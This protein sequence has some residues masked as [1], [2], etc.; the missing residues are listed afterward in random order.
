MAAGAACSSALPALHP[1][2]GC[3]EL[4]ALSAHASA[5]WEERHQGD[6][7]YSLAM[8]SLRRGARIPVFASMPSKLDARQRASQSFILKRLSDFGLEART[9]GYTD[10]GMFNPLHEVRTLARH[11][12]GGIILG[13][14]QVGASRAKTKGYSIP[15]DPRSEVTDV[16]LP[17]P[18]FA[19]T[20]WNQLETGILFGLSLPLFVLREQGIAGGI[21]DEGAS[22][23]LIHSMP[24]PREDWTGGSG[25][26]PSID[27]TEAE[28]SFD[29]ALMRW[30]SIVWANYYRA[31]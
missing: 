19:P 3:T 21:F 30:Q 23:V 25:E 16:N 9:V 27:N 24:M 31:T 7:W 6:M 11:C 4:A 22:D 26:P 20:P 1:P 14:R 13:Y 8:E 10:P 12:A 28:H 5:A 2:E 17:G 18:Y 29:D 15:G